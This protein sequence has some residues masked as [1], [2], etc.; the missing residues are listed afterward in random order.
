[1]LPFS[2]SLLEQPAIT[3]EIL[4]VLRYKY[5]EYVV[6]QNEKAMKH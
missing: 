5:Q 4:K 3:M 6:E 2:G 1:M